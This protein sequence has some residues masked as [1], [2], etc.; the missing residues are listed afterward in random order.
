MIKLNNFFKII[1]LLLFTVLPVDFL[2]SDTDRY[3][4]TKYRLL[5]FKEALFLFKIDV[6]RYPTS[7]EGLNSLIINSGNIKN[8]NG[9]YINN[10]F[11]PHDPW[12]NI[13]IYKYVGSS[14]GVKYII[15]SFGKNKLNEYGFGDD[16]LIIK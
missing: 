3:K 10:N 1:F 7:L 5:S 9:P 16:I 4:V 11:L 14:D 13:Y 2:L 12:G 6:K 15:Y 8:W